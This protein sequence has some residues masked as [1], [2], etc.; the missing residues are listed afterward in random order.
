MK[1]ILKMSLAVLVGMTTINTFANNDD[2]LLNVKKGTNK[3]ISFSVNQIKKANVTI[4]DRFHNVIY[5][6]I[7][8]GKEGI[9]KTFNLEEFPN[10][11][12]FLEVETNSKKVVHT[13]S[14]SNE[15]TTLSRK[16]MTEVIKSDIKN[17]NK[18]VAA[19]K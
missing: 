3:E 15:S 10:G 1:T 16:S 7:A 5:S 14:V 12:Y 19:T 2:F 18:N 11:V 8:T 13:I 6:E 17:N 4:I 9:S